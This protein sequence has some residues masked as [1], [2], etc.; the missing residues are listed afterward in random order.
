MH[1]DY[2]RGTVV[3]LSGDELEV[4][5]DKPFLEGTTTRRFDHHISFARWLT[6]LKVDDDGRETP[7][8]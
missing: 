3:L 4:E 7:A 2:G 8:T 5:W 6:P 1:S